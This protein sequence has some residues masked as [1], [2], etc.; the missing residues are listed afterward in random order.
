MYHASFELILG[1][2]GDGRR[3]REVT[4]VLGQR[5]EGRVIIC[6][7]RGWEDKEGWSAANK[8]EWVGSN[9]VS[10]HRCIIR[11][12]RRDANKIGRCREADKWERETHARSYCWSS[13]AA[14]EKSLVKKIRAIHRTHNKPI[15][16]P[17]RTAPFSPFHSQY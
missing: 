6:V 7:R 9:H 17:R 12:G 5:W 11:Q 3:E 1:K 8:W 15:S 13:P 16:Q 2:V 4:C 10:G 14:R